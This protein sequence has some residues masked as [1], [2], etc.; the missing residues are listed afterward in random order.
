VLQARGNQTCGQ[1]KFGGLISF[2]SFRECST[3]VPLSGELSL[4]ACAFCYPWSSGSYG[5]CLHGAPVSLAF[6]GEGSRSCNNRESGVL[7]S[8]V[9]R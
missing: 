5:S 2:M 9:C 1:Q 3:V 7:S 6:Q 4:L 8:C